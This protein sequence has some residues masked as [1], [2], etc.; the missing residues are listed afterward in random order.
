[1]VDLLRR[2]GVAER[3]D[4]GGQV[5]DGVRHR[6]CRRPASYRPRRAHRRQDRH[7]LRPDRGDPRSLRRPRRH[8]RARSSTR[9]PTSRSTTSTATR[10]SVTWRRTAQPAASPATSSPAATGSTAS[11]A[12]VPADVL[13]SFEKVYPFGWLGVLAETPPVER[14]ADLRQPRARLRALLACARRRCSRY[15]VQCALDERVEDWPDDRFWDELLRAR[16][17]G[18]RRRSLVTGPSIEKSDR[19]AAQLR[20]RADAARPAVPGRRCRPHR[21]AHRRQG[22]QPG[23]LATST[24]CRSADRLLSRRRRGRLEPIPTRALARDLEGRAL[25][26]VD[27]RLLH[28]FPEASAFE[29][30]DAGGPSWTTSCGHAPRRRRSPRTMSACRYD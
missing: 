1:M 17:P 4:R 13:A 24:T 23:R 3:L 28:R 18:D 20:R 2:A 21:A 25:L 26:V 10:P 19:A 11:A 30:A 5:H 27:D 7:R 6:V 16:L 12:S 9:R 14:R 8:G 15:Y 29:A 22:T